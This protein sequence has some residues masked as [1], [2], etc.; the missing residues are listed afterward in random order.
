ME[1]WP[2]HVASLVVSLS[3]GF[4]LV[5]GGSKRWNIGLVMWPALLYHPLQGL[6]W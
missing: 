5:V 1:H 4:E 6:K 3:S 2:C